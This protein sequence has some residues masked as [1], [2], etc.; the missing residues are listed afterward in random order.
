MFVFFVTRKNDVFETIE[1]KG[2]GGGLVEYI[3][4]PPPPFFSTIDGISS[5]ICVEL[6][7]LLSRMLSDFEGAKTFPN[8]KNLICV[9]LNTRACQ[10][11]NDQLKATWKQRRRPEYI[12]YFSANKMKSLVEKVSCQQ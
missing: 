10:T 11:C 5:T 8:K 3:P 7:L 9:Y 6:K 12:D 1:G 4:H 2:W